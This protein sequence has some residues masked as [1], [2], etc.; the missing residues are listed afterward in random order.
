MSPL[1]ITTLAFSISNSYRKSNPKSF[2]KIIQ[3]LIGCYLV[4]FNDIK[5]FN[6]KQLLINDNSI[7]TAL[8]NQC[9]TIWGVGIGCANELDDLGRYYSQKE[10]NIAQCSFSMFYVFSGKGGIIFVDISL[11]SMFITY[12]MFYNCSCNSYGGAIYFFST[13]SSLKMICANKCS[14]KSSYNYNFANI[15][16]IQVNTI[17][18]LSVSQC[19]HSYNGEYSY[20][21]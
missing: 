15:N 8:F 5:A 18:F 20:R 1:T 2:I 19:S 21:I 7:N 17:E 13:N 10:I 3:L 14:C 16:S 9:H 11:S 12:S 6:T 4:F